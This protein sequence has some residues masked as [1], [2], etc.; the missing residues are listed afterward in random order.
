[1]QRLLSFVCG[2]K[3]RLSFVERTEEREKTVLRGQSDKFCGEKRGIF[4]LLLVA[5]LNRMCY[6]E[7]HEKT[8]DH[9]RRT[10]WREKSNI[11]W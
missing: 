9:G 5:L 7:R 10:K 2:I 8:N 11:I 6:Y 4:S 1:M 3:S